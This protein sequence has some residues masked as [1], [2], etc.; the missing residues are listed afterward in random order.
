M[1]LA[2]FEAKWNELGTTEEGTIKC[3]L[4][5]ILEYLEGNKDAEK[6][7]EMTLP[8]NK[9][10]S[11]VRYYLKSQ[12]DKNVAGSY[13]GGTPDNE[14]TYSY[15]NKVHVD[16]K[17]SKRGKKESK[18]F[19]QSGGKDFAS[20]VHLKKNKDGYWKLF[21]VSSLATGVKKL[22]SEDDDF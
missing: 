9:I 12:F 6:M 4:I 11:R 10:D 8:K 16:S 7:I 15:D 19:V 20:P 14:Y 17:Q 18:I 1:K 2:E 3:F 13:L 22:T 5:G 21:N